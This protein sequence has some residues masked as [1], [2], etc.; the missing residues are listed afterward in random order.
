MNLEILGTVM[1]SF[2][3]AAVIVA[4]LAKFLSKVWTDRLAK[5]TSAKINRD[6]E[7]LKAGFNQDLE[8]L[9]SK[10]TQSIESLKAR[11]TEALEKTKHE[12]ETIKRAQE[13]FSGISQDFYQK[14]F[15][16]RGFCIS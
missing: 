8:V 1:G 6:L 16:K 5:Q 13:Q 4:A 14:F 12:L 10:S 3:G 2:G 15:D 7:S 9:K 11:N